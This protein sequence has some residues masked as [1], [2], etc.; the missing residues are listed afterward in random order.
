[1]HLSLSNHLVFPSESSFFE[2]F[3]EMNVMSHF[4][5]VVFLFVFLRTQI[6]FKK[7]F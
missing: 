7:I 5:L 6:E 4:C 3:W 1:M 2:E